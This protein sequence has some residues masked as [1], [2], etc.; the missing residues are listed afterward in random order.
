[1]IQIENKLVSL[2]ILEKKFVC[3]L[4]A[5]QGACCVE[6]DAGAPLS[7]EECAILDREYANFKDELS[8][9]GRKEIEK[10]GKWTKDEDGEMVTPLNKGKECAYCVFEKGIAKCGIENAWNKGM[11][12]FQKPLSCHLYPIRVS[13]LGDHLA[14]NYH[15]WPVCKPALIFGEKVGVPVFRFL[16]APIIRAFGE[17]FYNELEL[18]KEALPGKDA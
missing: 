4:D 6:G 18:V 3:N 11:T 8:P 2:E 12:S 15:S 10:H 16:K 17:D 9:E 5:C 7:E 1:M 13:K 14:L